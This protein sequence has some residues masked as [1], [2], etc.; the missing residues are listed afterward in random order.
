MSKSCCNR[1]TSRQDLEPRRLHRRVL[2]AVAAV[3]VAA[4]LSGCGGTGKIE[5]RPPEYS[6]VEDLCGEI[7]TS[8]VDKLAGR[9]AVLADESLL[10]EPDDGDS[11]SCVFET[12][13]TPGEF[14]QYRLLITATVNDV[15]DTAKMQ[16]EDYVAEEKENENLES[17]GEAD[18]FWAASQRIRW[19][20][21]S[22][23]NAVL[24][25]Q[26]GTLSMYVKV[27]KPLEEDANEKEWDVAIDTAQQIS[28]VLAK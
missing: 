22:M 2:S 7:D 20:P 28:T 23:C 24:I 6:A 27:V 12:D 5:D 4:G 1:G 16:Y 8:A 15:S 21:Q 11:M 17:L 25:V 26:D 3:V 10:G 19:G 14:D 18:G 13:S 9:Q